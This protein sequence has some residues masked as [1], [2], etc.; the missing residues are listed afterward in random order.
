MKCLLAMAAVAVA[1]AATTRAAGAGAETAKPKAY[2]AVFD[3]AGDADAGKQVADSTRIRL[4]RHEEYFVID[5]LT[6]QDCCGAV[7]ADADE[8]AVRE[9]MTAQLGAN[10]GVCGTLSRTGAAVTLKARCIDLTDPNK[11]TGWTKTFSDNTERWKGVI[12]G[13]LVEQIRGEP[14]WQPPQYG[15]LPEPASFGE[16]LNANGG[17]DQG[18]RG[19][20]PPDNCA[21]FLV[22]GP[23]GRGTVLKIR[24]DLP[25]DPWVEYHRK[26]I[27]GLANPNNPPNLPRDTSYGSVAGLEGVHYS[28]Q[29]IDAAPGRRYWL[30]A[31]V[32]SEGTPKIFVKG[33]LDWSQRAEGIPEAALVE[34][35]LTPEA[36]AKLPPERQKALIAMD[37]K[38]HPER[39]RR[40]CWRWYMN[41][42]A[43][44]ARRKADGWIHMAEP[45]PPRGGLPENVRWLQIQIYPYWPPTDYYFDNVHLY[46]DPA[47]KTPLPEEKPRTPNF[48][49]T[50]DV[51]EEEYQREHGG[52]SG[53]SQP[54]PGSR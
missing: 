22:K 1:A 41:C 11:P 48:G 49:R 34:L 6:I 45:F 15:D 8:K 42:G 12:A 17:F 53:A 23:P 2:V 9:L 26:L 52:K 18:H 54:A 36:F 51:V 47:Q 35:K 29:F 13:A 24:T 20:D 10:V 16:P 33:Y 38:R 19:W 37:A 7:P 25:N 5:R 30:V 14:E 28:G 40:E 50:S 27:L 39:Y 4:R 43:A 44:N 46:L 21:S 3:F 32:M 31:D